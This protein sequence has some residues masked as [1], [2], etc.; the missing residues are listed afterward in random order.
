MREVKGP[1]VYVRMKGGGKDE[2]EISFILDPILTI[3]NST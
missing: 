1:N 2:K 3:V